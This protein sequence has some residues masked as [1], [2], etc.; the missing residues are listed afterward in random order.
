VVSDADLAALPKAHLHLH[1]T[2]GMRH[3]TLV[4]LAATHGIQLPERLTDEIAAFLDQCWR[5]RGR[6]RR[7]AAA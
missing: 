1:L 6:G 3:D 4:E 5:P 7:R 2:G